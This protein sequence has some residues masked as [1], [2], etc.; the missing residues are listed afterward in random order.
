L[1][2][3]RLVDTVID[4]AAGV[5]ATAVALRANRQHR[6]LL[7]PAAKILDFFH[8]SRD[9]RHYRR[10]APAFQRVFAATIFF[11]TDDQPDRNH[12]ADSAHF[13]FFIKCAAA[14]LSKN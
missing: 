1:P 5:T 9:D 10:I 6:A 11:G 4:I 12:L 2:I 14:H 13:H 3:L 7:R 8:L